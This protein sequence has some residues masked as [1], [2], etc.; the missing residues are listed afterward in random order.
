LLLKKSRNL[1]T[2]HSF[3][4]KKYQLNRIPIAISG[5]AMFLLMSFDVLFFKKK[6]RGDTTCGYY[7]IAVKIRPY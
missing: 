1:T 2:K 7:G 3:S 5:M 4:Y 6:Y